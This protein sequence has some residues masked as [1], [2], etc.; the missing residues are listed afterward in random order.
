MYLKYRL[1]DHPFYQDW[2]C[3][4]ITKGQLSMYA[5]SYLDFIKEIPNY[6]QKVI[7]GLDVSDSRTIE[8]IDDEKSHISLW[9]EFASKL[10]E[11]EDY[12]EM[13]E[14]LNA[15]AKMT[16]SELLGAIHAFEIQQPEVA[17]T[18]REGLIEHYGFNSDE[19]KYFDE[20]LHEEEHIKFGTYLKN[21]HAVNEE[22]NRGFETGSEL[23]YN[24]LN[25]FM[26]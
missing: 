10:P 23:I 26:N 22:F 3:G 1:L 11:A 17:K 20:H 6:W 21:N 15:F 16:P 19:V 2:S 13:Y 7:A 24:S 4:K 12:P 18:K 9:Q 5:A 14:L 25:L 8:I